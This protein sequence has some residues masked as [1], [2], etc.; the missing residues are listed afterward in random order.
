MFLVALLRVRTVNFS[1][2]A[3]GFIGKAQ[4]ES[5]EKRLQR[6]FRGF[7]LDYQDIAKLVVGIMDIPQPWVL[8]VDR[9]NWQSGESTFNILMLG[10]V[11]EGVAFPLVWTMLGKK[12]NSNYT[13]RIQLL[14]E[15]RTIFPDVEVDCLTGDREFIGSQWFDYL[16][17]KIWTPFRLR[18]KHNNRLFDGRNALKASVVFAHLKPGEQQVLKVRRRIWGHWVYVIALRLEDNELLIVVTNRKPQSAIT[19]YAKCWDIETLFG[20][21]K[22]RGFCLEATHLREPER[23]R[24]MIALLTIA[25]CWAFKAGEW[26]AQ[27]QGIEIKSHGRKAKSTFRVG[28]DYL[29]RIFLNLNSFETQSLEVIRFLSCT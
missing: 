8:S 17:N 28:L 20:C 12:G 18:I 26:L 24:R 27:Q 1:E 5:C 14:E 13:E 22:T 29:R 3:Q 10:V 15:F 6:F 11:H 19:D 23:L 21:F 25:L 9:T 4:V 16:L 7:E 2:L